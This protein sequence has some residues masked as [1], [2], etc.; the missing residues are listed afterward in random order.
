MEPV[1]ITIRPI[2]PSTG[3]TLFRAWRLW[4]Y[5]VFV[6]HSIQ[7]TTHVQKAALGAPKKVNLVS[8]DL[9]KNF[10]ES[11]AAFKKSVAPP[12][13]TCSPDH[14]GPSVLTPLSQPLSPHL[15]SS[16]Y[17]LFHLPALF[18]PPSCLS[19]CLLPSLPCP[20]PPLPHSLT[21]QALQE[22]ENEG[23]RRKG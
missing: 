16:L 23:E 10:K 18:R 15:P 6:L 13:S 21:D 17:L 20:C 9:L 7:H 1:A 5:S 3:R 8:S 2:E 11:S 12:E 4:R 14:K 19:P 22:K